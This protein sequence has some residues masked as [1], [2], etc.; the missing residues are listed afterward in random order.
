MASFNTVWLPNVVCTIA[1]CLISWFI[2]WRQGLKAGRAADT[3]T[4]MLTNLLIVREDGGEL[5]L[6]RN[7]KGEVTGGRAYELKAETGVL[8][9]AGLEAKVI[10]AP[11][12]EQAPHR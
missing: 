4:R 11:I 9:V 5:K 12:P 1:G 3:H 2:G 8:A 7:E 6:V 10:R